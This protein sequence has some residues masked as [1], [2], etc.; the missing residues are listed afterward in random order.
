MGRKYKAGIYSFEKMFFNELN[1]DYRSEFC[2]MCADRN[3]GRLKTMLTLNIFLQIGL[4]FIMR[5]MNPHMYFYKIE[6][7]MELRLFFSATY[8]LY[9]VISLLIILKLEEL[10]KETMYSSSLNLFAVLA[11]MIG[12]GFYEAFHSVLEIAYSGSVYRLIASILIIVF[13]PLL[14]RRIKAGLLLYYML[15][16]ESAA[17][18]IPKESIYFSNI[19]IFMVAITILSFISWS[20]VHSNAIK[21]FYIWQ[22]MLEKIKRLENAINDLEYLSETDPLVQIANRRFI[23]SYLERVWNQARRD[24]T[25][26]FFMMADIDRFKSYNDTYGHT[27]GDECLK[28][29]AATMKKSLKRST[30]IVGRFGGEE[31]AV[32]LTSVTDEGFEKTAEKI[33]K[34]VEMLKIPNEG[35]IPY[36]YVTISIGASSMIPL[37]EE[38]YEALIERADKALY[39][40][41]DTGRNKVC[42][43][44]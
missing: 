9:N 8:V 20:I 3:I 35:N 31:F 11:I 2:K 24:R 25:K 40:A 37:G 36:G 5:N 22:E 16:V 18:Y 41:K 42:F 39:E 32:I 1:S 17:F 14:D 34:D 6:W 10:R 26:V 29:V 33:R 15:A 19:R 21:D 13:V 28:I 4:N 30:D 23:N 38:T 43:Y 27:Q 7:D 12:F 44:R